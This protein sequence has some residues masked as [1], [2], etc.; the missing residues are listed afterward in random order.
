MLGIQIYDH[1]PRDLF[2]T[3]LQNYINVL[4]KA[5]AQFLLKTYQK[6]K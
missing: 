6:S 4:L 2:A 3:E 5:K 1:N